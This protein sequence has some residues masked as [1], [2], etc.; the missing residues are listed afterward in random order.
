MMRIGHIWFTDPL[1][2]NGSGEI[3]DAP[4]PSYQRIDPTE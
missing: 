1:P 3:T 2:E 4:Y